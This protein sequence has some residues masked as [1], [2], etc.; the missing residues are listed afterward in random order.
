MQIEPICEELGGDFHKCPGPLC[1]LGRYFV[2]TFM[3]NFS[4]RS[5]SLGIGVLTAIS[6]SVLWE[7]RFVFVLFANLVAFQQYQDSQC[8]LFPQFD[9]KYMKFCLSSSSCASEKRMSI[10]AEPAQVCRP[11]D[12]EST[13][14]TSPYFTYPLLL[15][16]H[17]YWLNYSRMYRTVSRTLC[18]LSICP[19][20]W[21]V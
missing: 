6:I 12:I 19:I 3:S 21:M 9:N 7:T 17:L 16:L 18:L 13:I 4:K 8:I 10:F 20:T 1:S 5:L 11:S 14:Q 2:E 15:H